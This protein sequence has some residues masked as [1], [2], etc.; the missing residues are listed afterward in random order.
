MM[1]SMPGARPV[2][3]GGVGAGV[4]ETTGSELAP[5]KK[6]TGAGEAAGVGLGA[7]VSLVTFGVST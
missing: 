6:E 2:T 5:V 1:P 7:G 3:A 4:G